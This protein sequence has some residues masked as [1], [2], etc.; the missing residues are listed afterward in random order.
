MATALLL[1]LFSV[2]FFTSLVLLVIVLSRSVVDAKGN[3]FKRKPGSANVTFSHYVLAITTRAGF[4]STTPKCD[5]RKPSAL[6][7]TIHG[8]W[9]SNNRS[10]ESPTSCPV[11]SGF[12][13]QELEPLHEAL[14]LFWP[15]YIQNSNSQFWKHEWLKH[16]SCSVN[17]TQ[18]KGMLDYFNTTINLFRSHNISRYLE[19]DN[20]VPRPEP[21]KTVAFFNAISNDVNDKNINVVCKRSGNIS[22]AVE[23]RLCVNDTLQPVDCPWKGSSCRK[24]LYYLP[25]SS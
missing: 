16:G 4:C 15:S 2:V 8:L 19:N 11:S 22:V 13:L 14:N 20:I 6:P 5:R 9:P 21:Y 12:S 23:V 17:H 25:S 10:K 3:K 18:I 7:W 24:C 1:R